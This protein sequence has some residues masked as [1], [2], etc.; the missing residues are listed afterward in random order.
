M[1]FVSIRWFGELN[2]K[3]IWLNIA[4]LYCYGIGV[5][6]RCGLGEDDWLVVE[7]VQGDDLWMMCEVGELLDFI[8]GS[9]WSLCL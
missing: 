8:N 3:L 7:V 4:D 5:K 2:G 1:G 9:F 6:G